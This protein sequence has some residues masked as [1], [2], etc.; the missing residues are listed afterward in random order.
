MSNV[1]LNTIPFCRGQ[2]PFKYKVNI[3]QSILP[4][5]PPYRG[6]LYLLYT[7]PKQAV[8]PNVSIHNETFFSF[9]II[10]SNNTVVHLTPFGMATFVF[11]TNMDRFTV[12]SPPNV[13]I[14]N[15]QSNNLTLQIS[16]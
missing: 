5:L 9:E 12:L 14:E 13:F 4:Q 10:S 8:G 11:T 7:W 2:K 6:V 15:V 1:V 3:S 16:R